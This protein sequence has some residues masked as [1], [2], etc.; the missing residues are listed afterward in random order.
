M[1]S[2]FDGQCLEIIIPDLGFVLLIE[3]RVHNHPNK[4]LFYWIIIESPHQ[5][6]PVIH[7]AASQVVRAG[8]IIIVFFMGEML[9]FLNL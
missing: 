2:S 7:K 4:T 1:K 5:Y 8:F 3:K 9:F 6:P